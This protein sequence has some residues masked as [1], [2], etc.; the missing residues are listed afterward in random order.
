M[1]QEQKVLCCGTI[2]KTV[3]VFGMILMVAATV[4]LAFLSRNK[5]KEYDYIGRT[6]ESKN[7]ITISGQGKIVAVP[8]IAKVNISLS[9][10]KKTVAEAQKENSEKMNNIIKEIKGLGVA[11]KD[12]KTVSYNIYP[13]YDWIDGRRIFKG[14][15]VRQTL[16]VKIRDTEKISAVLDKAGS[17]GA[18]EIS[19]LNFEV[20]NIEKIQQEARV[21]AITDA[22]NKAEELAKAMGV[23]LG[24]I[25]AFYE[26]N[27]IPRPYYDYATKG[28]G[29]GGMMTESASPTIATGESE[30]ISNVSIT[31]ELL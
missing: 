30:I 28:E 20:D 14:Y 29:Y 2:K 18:N 23:K 11:D 9:T 8:D 26:N 31:F 4:Y 7:E 5:F 15:E 12:L 24:K 25:T 27:Y 22:K 1:T 6:A 16:E 21:Q 13:Q 19:D 3:M 10:I 17:L